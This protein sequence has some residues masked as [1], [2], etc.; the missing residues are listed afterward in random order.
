MPSINVKNPEELTA[1]Y[2]FRDQALA[3]Q[4]G[5]HLYNLGVSFEIQCG[6]ITAMKKDIC[7]NFMSFCDNGVSI[8][9]PQMH[10]P[11]LVSLVNS[12]KE[13]WYDRP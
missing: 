3:E 11:T 1:S 6:C 7:D 13:S 12:V 2:F 8:K 10:L 4:V 5:E 9:V